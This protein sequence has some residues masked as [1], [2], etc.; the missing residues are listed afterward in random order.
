MCLLQ[1][2]PQNMASL[3]TCICLSWHHS[4]NQPKSTEV[5]RNCSTP[6]EVFWCISLYGVLTN[7]AQLH[8]VRWTNT[9]VM[10]A[11]NP[12]LRVLSHTNF[13][14]TSSL[15][16]LLQWNVLSRV[17]LSLSPMSICPRKTPSNWPSEV[18]LSFHFTPVTP[19]P[20]DLWLLLVSVGTHTYMAQTHK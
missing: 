18:P 3:S 6:P 2:L 14:R 1:V 8:N 5:A 7:A 19:V 16:C 20:R 4:A 13:S 15:L 9:G 12:S 11:K 10:L 17:C